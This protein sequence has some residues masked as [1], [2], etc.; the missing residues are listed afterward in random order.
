MRNT[1]LMNLINHNPFPSFFDNYSN[2]WSSPQLNHLFDEDEKN[3]YS[4]V[5]IPGMNAED[6]TIET[7]NGTLSV[8]A[9]RE[10][11]SGGSQTKKSYSFTSNIPTDVDAD[12]IKVHYENGV[13][14][15][16]MPK[17]EARLEHSKKLQIS[18]GKKG[19]DFLE[20]KKAS[21]KQ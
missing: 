15:F 11:N 6:I 10:C 14:E 5:D 20:H 17:K 1:T 19:Q 4:S 3:Y 12:Q 9:E 21:T 13:L 2:E 7:K 8:K 16:V 18:T